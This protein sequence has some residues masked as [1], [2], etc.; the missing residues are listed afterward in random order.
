MK[1][2]RKVMRTLR[3]LDIP[4]EHWDPVLSFAWSLE[5]LSHIYTG[6]R[7]FERMASVTAQSA[8]DGEPPAAVAEVLKLCLELIIAR[9]ERPAAFPPA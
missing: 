2:E 3:R 4:H 5:S 7:L 9:T 8:R 1:F 6:D